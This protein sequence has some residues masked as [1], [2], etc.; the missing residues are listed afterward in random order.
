[1]L[2]TNQMKT[3]VFIAGL[4]ALFG[5]AGHMMG[6]Q[7]GMLLAL[8][9]AAAGNVFAFYMS[10]TLVLRMY[11]A[12]PLEH[13][14][15][16]AM[17]RELA[18]R[19][20]LPMPKVYLIRG[21]QPNAFATGRNPSHAAVAVTET[22]VELLSPAELRGVLAHELAHIERRDTLIMTITA[23]LAGAL[24]SLSHMFMFLGGAGRDEEGRGMHPLVALMVMILAPIAAMM[25]QM[26]ISRTREYGADAR[27]AEICGDPL[28]LAS[29]LQ[30]L[31]QYAARHMNPVA[32]S[33]PASAH[34]FIINP[35]HGQR[36]DGLF[37][38]HPRTENRVRALQ[39]YAA[40]KTMQHPS[41]Q[42]HSPP[43][44]EPRLHRA[45]VLGRGRQRHRAPWR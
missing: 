31:E 21:Q 1:M 38:T 15:L 37:S 29:A 36:M 27:G 28:A 14:N 17:V 12:Q 26:A 19:A 44:P 5:I 23:T 34:L 45:S 33:N 42:E 3:W 35:L 4:T 40:Q 18:A 9:M 39:S 43:S 7:G 30:K 2:L 10:D 20:N 8:L 22:L 16:V 6:G 13:G 32:E 25:V 11:G 41:T 24:S